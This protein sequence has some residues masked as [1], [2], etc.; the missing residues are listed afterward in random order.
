MSMEKEEKELLERLVKEVATQNK[1]IALLLCQKYFFKFHDT[2][3]PLSS[4]DDY[5]REIKKDS[6][7][8]LVTL[9]FNHL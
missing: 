9:G 5:L 7:K 6:E 2:F 1:L 3:S 8:V 4:F